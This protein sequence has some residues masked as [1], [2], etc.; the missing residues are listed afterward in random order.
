MAAELRVRLDEDFN[1]E[2]KQ[3]LRAAAKEVVAEVVSQEAR[4]KDWM[5]VKELQG[6]MNV[7]PNTVNS[8]IRN[9]MPVSIVGQKRFVKKSNLEKF[10]AEH[11]KIK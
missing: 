10:L 3:L 9:G 1:D 6:Y 11:E 5:S 2:F 4:A 7:S 8:W